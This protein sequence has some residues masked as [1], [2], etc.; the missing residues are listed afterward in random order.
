MD[1]LR[2]PFINQG[3]VVSVVIASALEEISQK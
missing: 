2:E 1:R 3:F